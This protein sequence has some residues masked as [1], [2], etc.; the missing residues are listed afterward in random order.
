MKL[1]NELEAGGEDEVTKEN[2]ILALKMVIC[3]W[4]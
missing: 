2:E 3:V 1:I 4:F